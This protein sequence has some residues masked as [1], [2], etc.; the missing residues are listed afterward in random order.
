MLWYLKRKW[1]DLKVAVRSRL[2]RDLIYIP[3]WYAKDIYMVDDDL[4]AYLHFAAMASVPLVEGVRLSIKPMERFYNFRRFK[5]ARKSI[6]D[7]DYTLRLYFDDKDE[8]QFEYQP[9]HLPTHQFFR[10]HVYSFEDARRMIQIK[11]RD[12]GKLLRQIVD[13]AFD[14]TYQG[15]SRKTLK[16]AARRYRIRVTRPLKRASRDTFRMIRSIETRRSSIDRESFDDRQVKARQKAFHDLLDDPNL[17][18][19]DLF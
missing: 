9:S 1:E 8:L 17:Q 7:G 12:L 10:S 13:E 2:D 5:L 11:K 18:I 16:K 6:Y 19:G 4:S 15:A 3:D 14:A